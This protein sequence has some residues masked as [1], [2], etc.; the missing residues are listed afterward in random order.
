MIQLIGHRGYPAL[1]PENT[2][3]SFQK[4][5]GSGCDGIELDLQ[6][7]KDNKV[8]VI[9]DQTLGRTTNGKGNVKDYTLKELKKLDAGRD[10]KIPSLEEVLK[11]FTEVVLVLELKSSGKDTF[12]LCKET[13]KLASKEKAQE[14]SVFVSFSLSA[15]KT[16]RE[17]LPS[18]AT[19]LIFSKPWPPMDNYHFLPKYINA[20]CPRRDRL[21]GT[22]AEFSKQNKLALYVWT[23]DIE[24]EVREVKK[25]SVTGI[26]SNDPGR[27]RR[28]I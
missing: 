19:G 26:V 4:A 17:L 27:V 1:Y 8:V 22:V 7:T 15:L 3:L 10:Q 23:V 18:A 20:I 24:E 11:S 6:L 21:N 25:F 28:F 9:H 2:M 5:I 13:I 14:R 12:R 16:I